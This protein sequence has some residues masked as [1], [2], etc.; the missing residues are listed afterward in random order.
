[1]FQSTPK[2]QKSRYTPLRDTSED[3]ANS[4]SEESIEEIEEENNRQ[5]IENKRHGRV[6]E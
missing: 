3:W 6:G 1:M 5:Q 2:N 4:K